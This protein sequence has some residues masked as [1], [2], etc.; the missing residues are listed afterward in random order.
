MIRDVYSGSQIPDPGSALFPPG[1]RIRICNNAAMSNS[2]PFIFHTVKI[3]T[4]SISKVDNRT[5]ES[6]E[7]NVK[8]GLV[9]R[10]G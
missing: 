5:V 4:E 10:Y 9:N 3:N 1:S 7:K 8:N 2:L 6:K